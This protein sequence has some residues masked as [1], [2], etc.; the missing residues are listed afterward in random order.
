MRQMSK[1]FDECDCKKA[2]P[3]KDPCK[4]EDPCPPKKS[5]C[6]C[7][8]EVSCDEPAE[9]ACAVCPGTGKPARQDM[10]QVYGYPNAIYGTNNYVGKPA[11]SIFTADSA[12]LGAPNVMQSAINGVTV[13]SQGQVTGAA[14]QL[15]CLN[16]APT[17]HNGI[18]IERN[19]RIM[20][21]NNCPIDLQ[22]EN[23]MDAVKKTLV[24]YE[25][26][27]G[28]CPLGGAAPATTSCSFPDVPQ[29]YWAACDIDKLAINDVVVGYPD[30]MFKP[31]RN[32]SRAEF[33]TMLV[34]GF[35]LDDCGTPQANLFKDVPMN[36]WANAAIAKAVDEDCSQVTLMVSLNLTILLQDAK[37]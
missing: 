35:N 20:D 36:N 5:D 16:E 12:I 13:S 1:T 21:G 2:D 27:E 29:G 34:K 8:D 10:K 18:P 19:E 30:G 28:G 6:G 3:C 24:P 26:K 31:N 17:R 32:I 11:S 37:L 9:P 33:A 4:D 25:I 15:P 23:S 7:P 14:A 22:T